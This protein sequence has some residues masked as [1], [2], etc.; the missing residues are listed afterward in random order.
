MFLRRALSSISRQAL[1][2]L[3]VEVIVIDSSRGVELESVVDEFSNSHWL[4]YKYVQAPRGPR[5]LARSLNFG[6]SKSRMDFVTF[7]MQDDFYISRTALLDTVNMLSVDGVFWSCCHSIHTT[8]G[9]DFFHENIPSLNRFIHLGRNS[10]S[11]PSVVAL[12]R[13][14]WQ[15]FN[16]HLI[17]LVDVD[18]Y[19]RVAEAFGEPGI[20]T[21][22]NV[23][24]GVGSH[25]LSHKISRFRK[26]IEFFV[27]SSTFL[28]RS[29]KLGKPNHGPGLTRMVR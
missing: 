6:F 28:W 2:E 10:I 4:I 21:N 14:A 5:S 13:L 3:T 15:N 25:Q 11:D 17:W 27:V 24:I 8:N 23:A 9:T 19:K 7:L 16:E 1:P 22:V 29:L 20:I 26:V 12:R 18:F